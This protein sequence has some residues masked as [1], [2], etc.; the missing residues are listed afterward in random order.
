MRAL[1]AFRPSSS[2]SPHR[3]TMTR[4]ISETHALVAELVLAVRESLSGDEGMRHLPERWNRDTAGAPPQSQRQLA[5]MPPLCRAFAALCDAEAALAEHLGTSGGGA[6]CDDGPVVSGGDDV[7][8][9]VLIVHR[10]ADGTADAAS[11][12]S[13]EPSPGRRSL[14]ER[15]GDVAPILRSRPQPANEPS[16]SPAGAERT[17]APEAPGIGRAGA[18]RRGGGAPEADRRA[19]AAPRR[20]STPEATVEIVRRPPAGSV[21]ADVRP[22]QP[23]DSTVQKASG[24]ES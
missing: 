21:A 19:E 23:D 12:S 22:L 10:R 24:K 14:K 18:Q 13:R 7:A 4:S 9:S 11:S 17:T 20:P 5:E 1:L 6:V 3:N 15:L 2:K 8:A 16:R